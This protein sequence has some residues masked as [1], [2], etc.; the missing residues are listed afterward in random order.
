MSFTFVRIKI[1]GVDH[2]WFEERSLVNEWFLTHHVDR[3]GWI[4][5]LPTETMALLSRNRSSVAALC[6]GRILLG[7]FKPNYANSTITDSCQVFKHYYG[8][9]PFIAVM[10]PLM[11]GNVSCHTT[12][13]VKK[14]IEEHFGESLPVIWPPN[15]S[16][17]ISV[18]HLWFVLKSKFTLHPCHPAMYGNLRTFCSHYGKRYFRLSILV[19][20]NQYSILKSKRGLNAN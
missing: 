9:D 18:E 19:L 10:F 1:T 7:Y 14:L 2:E 6:K 17:I 20:Q 3:R 4:Y 16:E 12:K 11:V 15:S 5:L 8:T 13:M